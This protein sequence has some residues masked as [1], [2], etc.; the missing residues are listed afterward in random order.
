MKFGFRVLPII[1]PINHQLL[2][3]EMCRGTDQN[4]SERLYIVEHIKS[5][6]HK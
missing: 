6:N 5:I 3:Q 4:V 2:V 1:N